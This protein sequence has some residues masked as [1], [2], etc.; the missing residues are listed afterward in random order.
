MQIR[1]LIIS[2]LILVFTGVHAQGL[3]LTATAS[4]SQVPTGEQFEVAFSINGEGDRFMPPSFSA[5]QVLSGPNVSSSTT[6]INGDF[7]A[8]NSYSYIL[9]PVKEGNYTIKSASIVSGGKLLKSNTLKITVVKGKPAPRAGASDNQGD[10][11]LPSQQKLPKNTELLFL[12]ARVDKTNVYAGEQ[13]SLD[14]KLYTLVSLVGNELDKLPELNGFWSQDINKNRQSTDWKTEVYNGHQYNSA[15]IKE[16][17]LFPQRS[18]KL[19]IDPLAMTFVARQPVASNDIFDQ[20]FGSFEEVK[21]RL[22][23]KPITINVKPLPSAGKP[24][25]FSGAV[26]KFSIAGYIDK[27]EI[28]AN[29]A[30]NYTFKVSGDGN[31]NLLGKLDLNF[32]K[33]FDKYDPKITD[34][35]TETVNGISGTRTYT[36]LLIPRHEGNYTLDPVSFT[37]FNPSAGKYVGLKTKAFSLKVNKGEV[38]ANATVLPGEQEDVELLSKDISYIKTR[39]LTVYKKGEGFYNSV[40]F[41]L[42]LC[43]GPLAAAGAF[44]YKNRAETFNSDPVKVKSRRAVKIASKH[45]AAAQKQLGANNTKA[46]YDEVFKG[47]YTYL[48]DK[49]NLPYSQLDKDIIAGKLRSKA[50]DEPL[51]VQLLE[52]LNQCEMARFAPVSS[53]LET[54]VLNQSKSIITGIEQK[55]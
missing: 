27:G 2:F 4:S 3:K 39:D 44:S 10:N 7:S 51:V 34:S 31:I 1:Y 14:Y 29:E 42:L 33:D 37:Y 41:Y 8:S 20:Y 22:K 45:M 52:T 53:R 47:L 28:K 35:L 40:W 26:G 13:I 6:I 48:S 46:F 54:Q 32:P 25:N 23:S 50:I 17:I 19:I 30:I 24:R 16:T 5:F 18:G 55:L 49:L 21:H 36:Y 12:K 11:Q 43:A 38:G 9:M 15:A